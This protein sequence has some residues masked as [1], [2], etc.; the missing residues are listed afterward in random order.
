[1]Q[2]SANDVTVVSIGS[3]MKDVDFQIKVDRKQLDVL[4]DDL[5]KRIAALSAHPN[6]NPNR[7]PIPVHNDRR[8]IR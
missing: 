8:P 1:M 4:C 6:L 3:L 2:L 5:Y 7:I